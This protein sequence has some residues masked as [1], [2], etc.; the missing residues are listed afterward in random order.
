MIQHINPFGCPL[1]LII[2]MYQEIK[3]HV[4][5]PENAGERFSLEFAKCLNRDVWLEDFSTLEAT[6][7]VLASGAKTHFVLK[8]EEILI[9]HF[10][11]VLED[12]MRVP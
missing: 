8:D 9:R 6:Q 1:I 2:L 10:Y 12:W 4:V 7:S 5:P 11:Q 3:M